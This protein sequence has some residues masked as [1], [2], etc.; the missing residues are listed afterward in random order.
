[1]PHTVCVSEL[2]SA[3]TLTCQLL[4]SVASALSAAAWTALS[5]E[6]AASVSGVSAGG[7]WR[8]MSTWS[9]WSWIACRR[10]FPGWKWLA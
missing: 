8:P 4:I 9:L 5:E 3:A 1:M 10:R 2:G 6:K 7:Q